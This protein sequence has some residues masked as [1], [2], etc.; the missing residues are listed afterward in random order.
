MPF[1]QVPHAEGT[2][3]GNCISVQVAFW[4]IVDTRHVFTLSNHVW[5]TIL[6]LILSSVK[7]MYKLCTEGAQPWHTTKYYEINGIE[8]S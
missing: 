4:R 2:T 7:Q 3:F 6:L 5:H 1:P 8:R